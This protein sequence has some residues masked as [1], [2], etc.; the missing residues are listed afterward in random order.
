MKFYIAAPGS[1]REEARRYGVLVES[2]DHEV[3]FKWMVLKAEGGQGVIRK[4][5][6][7]HREEA[8][9]HALLEKDAVLHCDILILLLPKIAAH[10]AGCFWEAGIASGTG[11]TIWIVGHDEWERDLVFTYLPECHFLADMDDVRAALE[12]ATA[13]ESEDPISSREAVVD[14]YLA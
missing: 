3:T 4:S 14:R 11:A 12:F 1:L 10:G 5:W 6:R 9:H 2:F 7:L 13:N 8:R